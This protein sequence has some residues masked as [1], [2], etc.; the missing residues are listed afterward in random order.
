MQEGAPQYAGEE[1]QCFF[2]KD[3]QA[4][5]LKESTGKRPSHVTLWRC[6]CLCKNQWVCGGCYTNLIYETG[7]CSEH[8]HCRSCL[9]PMGL[10][11]V[12]TWSRE[13][14]TQFYTR[15]LTM[16]GAIAV[17]WVVLYYSH[18][19][20]WLVLL[21]VELDQIFRV[22]INMELARL[23]VLHHRALY[24]ALA[25]TLLQYFCISTKAWDFPL[26]VA[27]LYLWMKLCV[28]LYGAK[29]ESRQK[30]ILTADVA[31]RRPGRTPVCHQK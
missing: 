18:W 9:T 5:L 31:P 28:I 23:L 14:E 29:E 16:V 27:T 26:F 30:V 24:P 2:C 17:L 3:T 7:P 13:D 19:T 8:Y 6:G 11:L 1:D 15:L 21:V 22:F 25:F 10:V 12:S 20:V 4:E